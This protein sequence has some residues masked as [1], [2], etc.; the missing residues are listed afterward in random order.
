MQSFFRNI[1]LIKIP[2]QKNPHS[3]R[4]RKELSSNEK[5]ACTIHVN[6]SKRS[7]SRV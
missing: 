4:E 3:Q 7:R 2:T 6:Q 5:N 1:V